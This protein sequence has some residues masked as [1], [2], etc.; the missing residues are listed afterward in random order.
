MVAP[1]RNNFAPRVGFA[2]DMMGNAKLV[3]RGGYG[4]FYDTI[5]TDSIAQENPPFNGGARTFRNG[6]LSNP[7]GSIGAVAPEP[8]DVGTMSMGDVRRRGMTH[9]QMQ[10]DRPQRGGPVRRVMPHR[11]T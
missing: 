4:I 11:R 2:L 9:R 5:N 10:K 3:M 7:F 6:L 8:G 1:D